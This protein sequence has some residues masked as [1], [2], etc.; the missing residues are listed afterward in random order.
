MTEDGL[1]LPADAV[2]PED[3]DNLLKLA[4]ARLGLAESETFREDI[5]DE[6]TALYVWFLNSTDNPEKRKLILSGSSLKKLGELH[7]VRAWTVWLKAQFDDFR[8]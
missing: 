7:D 4:A 2:S 8:T 5:P 3:C 1:T 6:E